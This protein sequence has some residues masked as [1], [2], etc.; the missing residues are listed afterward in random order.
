MSL[1]APH[2][3]ICT[4]QVLRTLIPRHHPPLHTDFVWVQPCC[5]SMSG[6]TTC[7]R[8]S[9]VH[10]WLGI[11]ATTFIFSNPPLPLLNLHRA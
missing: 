6:V 5:E 8:V 11:A 1:V 4:A 2:A 10:P 7:D 9:R 3:F